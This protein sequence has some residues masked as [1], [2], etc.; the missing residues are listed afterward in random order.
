MGNGFNFRATSGFVVDGAGETYDLGLVYP[1]TRGG[2]TFGWDTDISA[3][4]R[5]RDNGVDRRLAGCA[6]WPNGTGTQKTWQLDL[7]ATGTYNLR[8]ALGDTG[9][10]QYDQYLKILD[11]TT[12]L[13]T[14]DDVGG[15]EQDHFDD[16]TGVDRAEAD[17]PGANAASEQT[18][19]STTLKIVIGT[20]TVADNTSTPAHFWLEETGAGAA[21]APRNRRDVIRQ[22]ET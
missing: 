13:L 9:S 7:P 10:A 21:V 20:P 18:F 19:S 5:D 2:F 22:R 1:V 4:A 17:W 11:N 8:L 6:G 12:T 14:I 3:W 16:A 15:T